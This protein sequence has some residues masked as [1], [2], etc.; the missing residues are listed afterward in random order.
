MDYDCDDVGAIVEQFI[1]RRFDVVESDTLFSRDVD[2]WEYGYVDSLGVTELVVF[3]ESHFGI[4]L[5]PS[6]LFSSDFSRISGIS[7]IVT[8]LM[9][10]GA[11]DSQ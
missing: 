10:P 9:R 7:A 6:A 1:R 8:G 2:L 4:Q 3:L 11:G 5:P